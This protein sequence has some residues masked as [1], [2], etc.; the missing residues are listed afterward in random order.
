MT[1]EANLER[2][3]A[4]MDRRLTENISKV[5]TSL[6]VHVAQC[7]AA[8]VAMTATIERLTRTVGI[9]MMLLAVLA[10]GLKTEFAAK[11]LAL[12]GLV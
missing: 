7:T 9:G 6:E 11:I 3:M 5:G 1:A 12:L 10:I 4:D 8:H 2:R